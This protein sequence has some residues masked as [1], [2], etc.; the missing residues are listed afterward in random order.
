MVKL[1]NVY[2]PRR[3][4][5][6]LLVEVCLV[7]IAFLSVTFLHFGLNAPSVLSTESGYFKVGF[8]AGALASA[9]S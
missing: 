2:F 6:V 7:C 8:L 9:T 1:F 4:I 5:A 3:T